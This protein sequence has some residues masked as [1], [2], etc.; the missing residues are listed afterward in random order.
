[1]NF[2]LFSRPCDAL[3]CEANTD[4]QGVVHTHTERITHKSAHSMHTAS[5]CTASSSSGGVRAGRAYR[6]LH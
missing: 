5:T 3:D 2:G 4:T 1:M 6:D